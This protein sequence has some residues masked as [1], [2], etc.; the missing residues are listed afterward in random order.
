MRKL[1][2]L[3]V[4]VL[5]ASAAHAQETYSVGPA[6]A[7]NVTTVGTVMAALN[8]ETCLRYSLAASCTQAQA[9]AAAGAAGGSGCTASQ[10]RAAGVR[11]WPATFA[12]RE[13]Y[14]TFGITLPRFLELVAA[15][16][17]ETRRL[18]CEGW[19][20]SNTTARNNACTALGLAA[21]CDP[22]CL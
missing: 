13:E 2:V 7:G 1:L 15:Q 3:A 11:I 20:A 14:V 21:G 10:A 4:L 12:G 19:N 17:Q 16:Q 18:F 8:R 9:C 6:S 5:A 22:V